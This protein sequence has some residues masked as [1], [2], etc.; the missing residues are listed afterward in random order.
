VTCFSDCV[1]LFVIDCVVLFS[2]NKYD[3]ADVAVDKISTDSASHGPR[4]VAEPLV[5]RCFHVRISVK[6]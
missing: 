6:C 4:A 2:E 5:I 1:H 3:D